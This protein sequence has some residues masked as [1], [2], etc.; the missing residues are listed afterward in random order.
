MSAWFATSMDI[1]NCDPASVKG[2]LANCL[3]VC[4]QNEQRHR[5]QLVHM[6]SLYKR[7]NREK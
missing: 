1:L 2:Y 6:C 3:E 4:A 7:V 5:K